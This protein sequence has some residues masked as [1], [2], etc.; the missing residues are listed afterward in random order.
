MPVTGDALPELQRFVE[1]AEAN[2]PPLDDPQA[3]LTVRFA[4]QFAFVPP[5]EPLHVQYHGPVPV[6]V[7]AVLSGLH[8][9][10]VGALNRFCP[11]DDP[12][13]PLTIRLAKQLAVV[14]PFDPLH[15]Q[16]HGPVPVTVEAVL[17]G[18]HR[19]V[20]GAVR[21]ICPLDEPQ[22]PLTEFDDPDCPRTGQT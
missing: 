21:K 20:V 9:F 14:P 16:Y 13:A 1:G 2:V 18:L 12:Q 8:R 3:P 15:V 6:T 22:A 11:L 5:F 19:F 17:S 4:K 7:E 10:A